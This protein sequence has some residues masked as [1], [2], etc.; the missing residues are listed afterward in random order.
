MSPPSAPAHL[1]V[2]SV[3]A[4]TVTLKWNEPLSFGNLPLKTYIIEKL[5][6]ES[7]EGKKSIDEWIRYSINLRFCMLFGQILW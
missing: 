1:R 3:S 5:A 2:V 6:S 7:G 4:S